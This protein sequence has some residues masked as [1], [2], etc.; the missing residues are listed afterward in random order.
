MKPKIG[1]LFIT[2]AW[3]RDVG[4]QDPGS[5]VTAEVERMGAEIIERF[6]LFLDPVYSGILFSE[7]D[8]ERASLLIRS[9]NVDGLIC[10]S[11]IPPEKALLTPKWCAV[12]ES[13]GIIASPVVTIN[14]ISPHNYLEEIKC[15]DAAIYLYTGWFDASLFHHG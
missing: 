11:R 13:R 10:P 6:S 12:S 4:L 1:I 2:S 7:K 5:D 3:F 9:E 8:A 14:D 15:S